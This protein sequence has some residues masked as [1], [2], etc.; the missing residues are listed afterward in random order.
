M[1]AEITA[2]RR[3]RDFSVWSNGVINAPDAKSWSDGNEFTN[4]A[5]ANA[6]AAAVRVMREHPAPGPC[7]EY[8]GSVLPLSGK[9]GPCYGWEIFRSGE[10]GEQIERIDDC[11]RFDDDDDALVAAIEFFDKFAEK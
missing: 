1:H 7:G 4:A 8:C 11:T 2:V 5:Y 10:Y 3:Y 6:V 9:P